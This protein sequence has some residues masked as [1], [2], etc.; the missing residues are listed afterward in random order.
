MFSAVIFLFCY[1]LLFLDPDWFAA[2]FHRL[3]NRLPGGLEGPS[4]RVE[5]L[6]RSPTG[7]VAR[8]RVVAAACR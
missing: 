4:C 7:R 6:A 5:D 3:A 1:V 2:R 8:A